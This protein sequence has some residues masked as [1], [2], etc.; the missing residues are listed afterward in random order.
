MYLYLLKKEVRYF[1]AD[2]VFDFDWSK[3]RSEHTTIIHIRLL[4]DGKGNTA[5]TTM[6]A[7][8]RVFEKPPT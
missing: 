6:A 7:V 8:D 4:K 2:D 3:L 5:N 1:G